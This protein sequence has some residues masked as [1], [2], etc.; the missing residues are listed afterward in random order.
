MGNMRNVKMNWE[1]PKTSYQEFLP[2]EYCAACFTATGTLTCSLNNVEHGVPCKNTVFEFSLEKGVLTG[3][4]TEYTDSSHTT[5]KT[6]LTLSDITVPCGLEDVASW[7][8]TGCEN[9]TWKN[10]DS[11][12]HPYTHIGKC[13]ITTYNY[14]IEHRPNH[15]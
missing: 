6:R 2:Q 11:N 13:E 15:S 9:T 7:K 1:S 10:V 8:D 12:G 14:L 3:R 5:V 4:A